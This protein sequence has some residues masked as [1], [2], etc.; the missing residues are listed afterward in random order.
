MLRSAL[1]KIGLGFFL[2]GTLFAAVG[3]ALGYGA[4]RDWSAWPKTEAVVSRIEWDDDT[5]YPF[6]RFTA[7]G[8]V[9]EVRGSVGSKPPSYTE[10]ERVQ[11]AYDP[12]TLAKVTTRGQ[13]FLFMAVF[14]GIGLLFAGIGGGMLFFSVRRWRRSER[15]RR[16]GEPG[17]ADILEVRL[18]RSVRVNGRS[19]WVI[20]VEWTDPMGAK[21]LFK[22][23]EL[24]ADPTPSL[25]ADGRLPVRVIAGAPE[26]HWIDLS[27]LA[28]PPT[29]L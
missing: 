2:F 8:R 17:W 12:K 6:F 10:G 23:E 7:G 1:A 27:A 25:P 26:H 11:V 21:H 28:R 16:E 15:A 5:A 14:G 3:G 19:P 22:T 20:E 9:I 13:M 24:W 4:H 18:D 29:A